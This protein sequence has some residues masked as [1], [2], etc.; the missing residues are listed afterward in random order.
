MGT[1]ERRFLAY[2]TLALNVA[3]LVKI[4]MLYCR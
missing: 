2:A 1:I 3:I 4:I